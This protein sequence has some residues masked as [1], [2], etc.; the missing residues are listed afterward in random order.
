[1]LFVDYRQAFGSVR[2]V[3]R[4]EAMWNMEIALKRMKLTKMA[5]RFTEAKIKDGT[6]MGLNVN[7]GKT[8]YMLISASE[9]R[10]NLYNLC[11]EVVHLIRLINSDT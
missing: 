2:R 11:M 1:M 8:R 7:I 10:K 9:G 4:C 3:K 5:M 6:G